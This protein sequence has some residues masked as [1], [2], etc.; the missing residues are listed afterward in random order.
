MNMKWVLFLYKKIIILKTMH[1]KSL[2]DSKFEVRILLAGIDSGQ[3]ILIKS[4]ILRHDLN[5]YVSN[6][7]SLKDDKSIVL[8]YSY[9]GAEIPIKIQIVPEGIST[10]LA[11]IEE[12][13]RYILQ[14]ELS[15]WNIQAILLR[16]KE[17]SEITFTREILENKHQLR[18]WYHT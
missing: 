4:Y 12:K 11:A 17:I 15:R 1:A 18:I 7:L 10:L 9:Q 6:I 8:W 16:R 2:Q 14:E 13:Y 5:E 3:L